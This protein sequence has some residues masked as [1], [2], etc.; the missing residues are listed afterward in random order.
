M[1]LYIILYVKLTK[2]SVKYSPNFF[3]KK[4]FVF[5]ITN[6]GLTILWKKCENEVSTFFANN[7]SMNIIVHASTFRKERINTK[8]IFFSINTNKPHIVPKC[9]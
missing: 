7:R 4:H 1:G 2:P 6:M 5:I 3:D 9:L 8:M